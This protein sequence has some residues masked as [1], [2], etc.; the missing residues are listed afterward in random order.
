MLACA[1][2]VLVYALEALTLIVLL[3]TDLGGLRVPLL[4]LYLLPMVV[5]GSCAVLVFF[6]HH[7]D[8]ST[9]WYGRARWRRDVVLRT[10]TVDRTW[11]RL[12]DNVILHITLHQV[13]HIFPII[14]HYHLQRATAAFRAAFPQLATVSEQSFAAACLRN[15]RLYQRNGYVADDA[16]LV[17]MYDGAP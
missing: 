11:G 15:L 4:Q 9:R 14:P 7:N 6:A 10:G 13:H 1:L 17:N 16:D 2:S 3:A 8:A 12:L 5:F